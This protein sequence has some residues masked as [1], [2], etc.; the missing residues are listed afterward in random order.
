VKDSLSI[1]AARDYVI[2]ATFQLKARGSRRSAADS[3]SHWVR[4]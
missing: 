4:S 3:I 2:E 1:I